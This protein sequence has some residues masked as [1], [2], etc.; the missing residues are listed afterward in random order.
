MERSSRP[1]LPTP[2][3]LLGEQ[4]SLNAVV[5]C[6]RSRL[7]LKADLA[8]NGRGSGCAECH[9]ECR[10]FENYRKQAHLGEGQGKPATS[11]KRLPR[12][13]LAA[14][15]LIP[16]AIH[17]TGFWTPC[18]RT[19]SPSNT[20]SAST[21]AL[22]P[23]LQCLHGLSYSMVKSAAYS[24]SAY[25]RF[26]IRRFSFSACWL[27]SWFATGTTMAGLPATSVNR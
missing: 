6:E 5:F 23:A 19:W 3:V 9:F 13:A 4:R 26:A 27:L 11:R 24:S 14:K 20:S 17:A 2:G 25:H 15:C 22:V 7:R 18:I 21:V 10:R 12:A 16:W 8:K 1:L